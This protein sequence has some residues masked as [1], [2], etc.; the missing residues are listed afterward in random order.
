M[1][2]GDVPTLWGRHLQATLQ[3][4]WPEP[5]VKRKLYTIN[6]EAICLVLPLQQHWY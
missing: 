1:R 6:D 2:A 4:I 3:I 5:M